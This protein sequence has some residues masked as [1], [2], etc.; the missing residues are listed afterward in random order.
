[1]DVVFPY[2]LF[3]P[4]ARYNKYWAIKGTVCLFVCFSLS[5]S[6]ETLPLSSVALLYVINY[7]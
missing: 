1:M 3:S 5:L 6:V 4:V 2:F 7:V